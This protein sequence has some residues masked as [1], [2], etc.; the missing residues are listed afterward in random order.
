MILK[1]SEYLASFYVSIHLFCNDEKDN[2]CNNGVN[3]YNVHFYL[4]FHCIMIVAKEKNRKRKKQNAKRKG[5]NKGNMRRKNTILMKS[6]MVILSL[7][8]GII[9]TERVSSKEMFTVRAE[10]VL[11]NP[12]TDS[13]GVTTWD[14]IYFGNYYQSLYQPIG[15]AKKDHIGCP[16]VDS[17]GTKYTW[18]AWLSSDDGWEGFFKYEPIKW[19]VLSIEGNKA[20]LVSDVCLDN[21]NDVKG[22]LEKTWKNSDIREWLNGYGEYSAIV[23]SSNVI[24]NFMGEAFNEEEQNAIFTTTVVNNSCKEYATGSCQDTLDKIFLLSFDEITNPAYG[25]SVKGEIAD[26]ARLKKGTEYACMGK[27]EPIQEWWLR[28][29]E[30]GGRKNYRTSL[31]VERS[32]KISCSYIGD[33]LGIS[34]ALYLDLSKNEVWSYAGTV[35][36]DEDIPIC[37]THIYD[38]G[39]MTKKVTC[40]EDGEKTYICLVCGESKYEKIAAKGHRFEEFPLFSVVPTCME[41]GII[42]NICMICGQKNIEEVAPEGHSFIY[43]ENYYGTGIGQYYCTRCYIRKKEEKPIYLK[44]V[45]NTSKIMANKGIKLKA[46]FTPENYCDGKLMWKSSNEQYAI[47]SDKGVVTTKE[48]GIGKTVT[49]TATNLVDG[50][51]EVS[52]T[53][54]IQIVRDA[55]KSI[56]LKASK[57]IKAGKKTRVK[58]K[59]KTTGNTANKNLYWSVNNTKYAT[60]NQKGVVKAKRAGKGKTIKVTACAVD[61]SGKKASIKIKIR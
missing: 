20:L 54:Q 37:N 60:I 8:F 16:S 29:G 47:V 23:T 36:S 12:R 38:N 26:K 14:C 24:N 56:S 2:N 6:W 30:A 58:A 35:S 18:L 50:K 45:G 41:K 5:E 10:T 46:Q 1:T 52:A 31:R 4:K 13:D 9:L 19:R 40:T 3:C 43:Y 61:G 34:P 27:N 48:Y 11:Q 22:S 17:D 39:K 32:G 25:Y 21:R 44:I 7:I 55:V 57:I 42:E 49:I 59:I 33:K 15:E 53:Y 28:T 51:E